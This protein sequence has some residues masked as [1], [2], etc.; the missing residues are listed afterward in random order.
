MINVCFGLPENHTN[1]DSAVKGRQPAVDR[2]RFISR[3]PKP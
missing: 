3:R 2:A 1:D